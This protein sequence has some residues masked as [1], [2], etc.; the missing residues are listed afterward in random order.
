MENDPKVHSKTLSV[1]KDYCNQK[2]EEEFKMNRFFEKK[3]K[4][5]DFITKV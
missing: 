4:S 2:A 1:I 5:A 3:S